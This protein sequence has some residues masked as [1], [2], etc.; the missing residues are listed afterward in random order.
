[1]DEIRRFAEQVFN[2]QPFSAFL[3]AKLTNLGAG[4]A[5][6]TVP[7]VDHLEQQHGHV[8]GG[9]ITYL[10]D[11][12]LTFAGGLALSGNALTSEFKINY[13][14]PA[15]G[16]HLVAKANAKAVGKRQAVCQCE[17]FFVNGDEEQLIA[18]AQG[19]IVSSGK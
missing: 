9:L 12:C 8:H 1:M 19:T 16:S 7:I 5:E 13:L 4:S 6:I 3:G 10:A 2:S 14:K 11:N 17:I 18:I 15:L